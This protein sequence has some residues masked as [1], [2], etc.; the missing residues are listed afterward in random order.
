MSAESTPQQPKRL[1]LALFFGTILALAGSASWLLWI[2]TS[3]V[4]RSSA[5]DHDRPLNPLTA[6]FLDHNIAVL[7]LPLP[8]LAVAVHALIRGRMFT[9][10]LVLFSS[11]L[12]LTMGSFSILM[13]IGLSLPWLGVVKPDIP[14]QVFGSQQTL[15]AFRSA[16][17][18][19]A[20]R[21]HYRRDAG[22]SIYKLESYDRGEQIPLTA[23]QTA[24]VQQIF[25][26][27]STYGWQFAKACA[28][29]Y[30]VLFTARSG[31]ATVRIALCFECGIFGVF[32]SADNSARAVNREVDFAPQAPASLVKRI[33][34]ADPEIQSLK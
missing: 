6:F 12:I 27:D 25:T 22:Q 24:L 28:P 9:H 31:D 26:K 21:L 13:A 11:T 33:F 7:L 19:T 20:E 16:S 1:W 8:W 18:M 23:D 17:A 3:L 30:G 5:F 14:N 10:Q 15:G 32:D 34:P 29:N 4:G 2:S